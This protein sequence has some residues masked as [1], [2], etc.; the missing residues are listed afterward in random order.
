MSSDANYY[1]ELFEQFKDMRVIVI[2]DVMID[3]YIFGQVDRI[4]PEAPVPVVSVTKRS[5]R[6]GGA[7]NVALN[8]KAMGATSLL[9]SV[10]GLDDRGDDF[11]KLLKDEN[12][13]VDGI[14][15]SKDRLT[16]TKFRVIGNN[17]QLLRVDE[18]ST[19]ALTSADELKLFH[20][21]QNLVERYHPDAIIFQD[22]DKGVLTPGVIGAITAKANEMGLPVTVDP[23]KKNFRQYKHVDLFKP[24]LKEL[25]EGIEMIIPRGDFDALEIAASRIQEEMS[26]RMVMVTLS[27]NGVY[28][29]SR[30]SDSSYDTLRLP[31]HRRNIADVSGAGDTVISLAT[32][33]LAA[34]CDLVTIARVSNL[35]GGLVCEEVGVVP[36]DADKL[37]QETI[38]LYTGIT[39]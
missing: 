22:Y 24:N 21:F 34:R 23:K 26:L 31:A 5:S 30:M 18:E 19:N 28:I 33:C 12:M 38:K 37:L 27:E 20:L 7:A 1:K 35:A 4:S 36:V 17:V 32:L 11:L 13:P 8:L 16:T 15:R 29:R 9:C 3:A 6:L 2:G 25:R 39:E 10:I 14:L